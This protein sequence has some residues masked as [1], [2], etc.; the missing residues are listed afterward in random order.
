MRTDYLGARKEAFA[1][2]LMG[3]WNIW[4]SFI[5]FRFNSEVFENDR[6]KYKPG[7]VTI[8]TKQFH[9]R[10][11]TFHARERFSQDIDSIWVRT[12]LHAIWA[13]QCLKRAIA[14]YALDNT[15]F[16]IF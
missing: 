3:A 14:I 13:V 12:S 11:I 10:K 15:S 5:P 7:V 16:Y 9:E 1:A 8:G 6:K 4:P 2:L